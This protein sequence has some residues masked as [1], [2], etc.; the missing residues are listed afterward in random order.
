MAQGTVADLQRSTNLGQAATDLPLDTHNSRRRF[1]ASA[2]MR[3]I[4]CGGRK[5]EGRLGRR[6][7]CLMAERPGVSGD[8]VAAQRALTLPPYRP[9]AII[10]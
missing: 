1:D 8:G 10:P 2:G 7:S 4:G 3:K 5:R 6:P 9:D